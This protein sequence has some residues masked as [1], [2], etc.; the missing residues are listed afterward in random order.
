MKYA[1]KLSERALKALKNIDNKQRIIIMSWIEKNL[2]DCENPRIYG[3]P[4][5]ANKKDYWKY[6]VGS[7]RLIAD[8]K[9][10]LLIIIII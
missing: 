4:L 9:N 10:N 1:V 8:I 2:Q 5:V 3:H 7:Y 6:R